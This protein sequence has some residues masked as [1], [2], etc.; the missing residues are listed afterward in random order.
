MGL[1]NLL[2][3]LILMGTVPS[4]PVLCASGVLVHPCDKGCTLPSDAH[5]PVESGRGCGHET[6]CSR[7][8]CGL[9]MLRNHGSF[10]SVVPM[11][12]L[13]NAVVREERDGPPLPLPPITSSNR[14]R[15]PLACLPS[16]LPLLI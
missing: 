14:E 8:P 11:M 2:L 16:D 1:R 12:F 10:D 13:P 5:H 9:V 7:D 6:G 15:L 4:V 3:P